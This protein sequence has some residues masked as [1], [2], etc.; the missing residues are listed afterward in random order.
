MILVNTSQSHKL[1]QEANGNGVEKR[2]PVAELLGRKID[3]R[4]FQGENTFRGKM[5]TFKMKCID[6]YLM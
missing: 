5:T 3:L 1:G 2:F 4:T 6:G